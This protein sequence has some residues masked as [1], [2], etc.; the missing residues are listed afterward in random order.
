MGLNYINSWLTKLYLLNR[1]FSL[2]I[3]FF[4]YLIMELITLF[5]P[6]M[7]FRLKIK[8]KV[9]E[10]NNLSYAMVSLITKIF[11][12][13]NQYKLWIYKKKFSRKNS[14]NP[15]KKRYWATKKAEIKL[16]KSKYFNCQ[17]AA[18]CKIC[19]KE[20]KCE[21]CNISKMCIS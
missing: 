5:I 17:F 10:K 2:D 18:K 20:Y 15:E 11:T 8:I 19:V 14:K 1:L 13:V 9:L 7:H 6:R 12:I 16:V 4:F 21:I 3:L